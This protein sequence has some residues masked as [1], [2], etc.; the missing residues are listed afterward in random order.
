[1]RL[2]ADPY[3]R[4]TAIAAGFMYTNFARPIKVLYRARQRGQLGSATTW[5][6]EEIATLLD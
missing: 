6:C 4:T 2:I 5:S 3:P 1:M